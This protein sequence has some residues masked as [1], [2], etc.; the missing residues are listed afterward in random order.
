MCNMIKTG[1]TSRRM[2]RANNIGMSTIIYL[3]SAL[4]LITLYAQ[5]VKKYDTVTETYLNLKKYLKYRKDS[6]NQYA[7]K[8]Y[9][10]KSASDK[11]LWNSDSLKDNNLLMQPSTPQDR[12]LLLNRLKRTIVDEMRLSAEKICYIKNI[13]ETS[14]EIPSTNFKDLENILEDRMFDN[15]NVR[16]DKIRE[17]SVGGVYTDSD[18]NVVTEE[19]F[20][21]DSEDNA[22]GECRLFTWTPEKFDRKSAIMAYLII[23]IKEYNS[24]I[25]DLNSL[26]TGLSVYLDSMHRIFAES[27]DI[28]LI[29]MCSTCSS[30][31]CQDVFCHD[32]KVA[33]ELQ[34]KRNVDHI[35]FKSRTLRKMLCDFMK[36][37][38][39]V[40]DLHAAIVEYND[41][42]VVAWKEKGNE[43]VLT[44]KSRGGN[45]TD[46]KLTL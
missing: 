34:K 12:N 37:Y 36:K 35:E 43:I 31:D 41:K 20:N 32:N 6:A 17:G 28:H 44:L 22:N 46:Y 1:Y 2:S 8:N 11:H 14:I 18:G 42:L 21:E 19:S 15:P 9:P 5:Y 45:G 13:V 3:A 38:R 30:V 27:L 33:L 40:L 39:Y 4:C 26:K 29:G 16:I 24:E 7:I 10:S 23:M 25:V